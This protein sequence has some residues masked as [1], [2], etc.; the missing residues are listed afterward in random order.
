[1][2]NFSIIALLVLDITVFASENVMM[3]VPLFITDVNNVTDTLVLALDPNATH[4]VDSLLGEKA[5]ADSDL[6][7]ELNGNH[8]AVVQIDVKDVESYG[9]RYLWGHN[10]IVDDAHD[11]QNAFVIAIAEER[12]PVQVSWNSQALEETM[13][14]SFITDWHPGAWFDAGYGYETKKQMATECEITFAFQIDNYEYIKAIDQRLGLFYV[15]LTDHKIYESIP[16]MTF[17]PTSKKLLR[18]GKVMIQCGDVRYTVLGQVV[19]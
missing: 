14:E 1:M 9:D 13:S 10:A 19:K 7:E 12:F 8:F 2:K 6:L 15:S 4:G 5:I 16:N 11:A 18:D 3:E 17:V